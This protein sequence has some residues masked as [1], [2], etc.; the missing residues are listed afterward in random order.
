LKQ[1]LRGIERLL[2]KVP[3]EDLERREELEV[4]VRALR[5][6]IGD[7]QKIIQ[8]KN[9]AEKAHGQ[10]FLDRQRLTRMEKQVRKEV[11]SS[12]KESQLLKIALDQVYVAHHPTDIKYSPLFR[13][14]QRVVDT[15]RHLFRRAVT[16][17]R[18]LT[19]LT[20]DKQTTSWIS[21]DQYERL[22]TSEWT[23][24]DEEKCFGGSITRQ[25]MK[26]VKKK[27]KE[28]SSDSRF[29]LVPEHNAVL[30][31][32]QQMD[33]ELDKD[34]DCGTKSK[35]KD[36]TAKSVAS[37]MDSDQSGDPSSG[38]DNDDDDD[39]DDKSGDLPDPL[40]RLHAQSNV[41]AHV[42]VLGDSSDSSDTDD[43]ASSEDDEEGVGLSKQPVGGSGSGS[44][45]T[46]S[47]SSSS[48]VKDEKEQTEQIRQEEEDDGF[49]MDANSDEDENVFSMTLKQVP[50][51]GEVRGDKTKG[52]ETQKQRPGQFKKR[53]MR[54]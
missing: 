33:A 27:L 7:K 18:I 23:I 53:R 28:G 9:N 13:K 8:E 50:A 31:I 44:S 12:E 20:R 46:S 6:E 15:S 43:S 39:D 16:R 5:L 52:W 32:A 45:G 10:R 37:L 22:P 14:G 49:L 25:G 48:S 30:E 11:D 41:L 1:Q 40:E 17:R 19:S 36:A 3:E 54:R 24:Q 21:K 34:K 4:K 42:P 51:L 2:L 35:M 38:S 26:E 47:D 29:A